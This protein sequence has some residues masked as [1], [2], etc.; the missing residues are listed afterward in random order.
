MRVFAFGVSERI[1]FAPRNSFV[2]FYAGTRQNKRMKNPAFLLFAATLSA[3][4][5]P[6]AGAA[7]E[8]PREAASAAI[9]AASRDVSVLVIVRDASGKALFRD[10]R[11]NVAAAVSGALALPGLVPLSPDFL[12]ASSGGDAFLSALSPADAANAAGADCVLEIRLAAPLETKRGGT[13]YARQTVFYALYSAAGTSLASGRVSGIFDAPETNAELRG[14]RAVET[15]EDAV[16]ELSG[17]IASG[18]VKPVPADSAFGAVEVV[19]VVEAPAF[20]LVEKKADGTFAVADVPARIV[21]PGVSLK[22]GGLDYALAPNGEPTTLKLPIGRALRVS[23]SHRDVVPETRTVKLAA[24]E[25]L[26]FS[27]SLTEAA[28]KRWLA[29]LAAMNAVVSAAKDAAVA[30]GVAETLS[31]AEA[32]KLRGI[33]KFWENSGMKIVR[34]TTRKFSAETKIAES[35]GDAGVPADEPEAK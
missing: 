9:P 8:A 24:G 14:L 2:S 4:A 10:A 13:V 31:A 21:V 32:E 25:R 27:L 1:S 6:C 22:I 3:V 33:A 11:G 20:P 15:A 16:A 34:S 28:K 30:R 5:F 29:D 7:P 18:E 12:E 17:K 19:C 26:T 23:V 35:E